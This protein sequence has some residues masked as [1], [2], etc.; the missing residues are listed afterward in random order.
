MKCPWKQSAVALLLVVSTA[1]YAD[2]PTT[3][4]GVNGAGEQIAL[5]EE[6]LPAA[7]ASNLAWTGFYVVSVGAPGE[8]PEKEFGA[9]HCG[10]R[11]ASF[12]C[13]RG[14]QS[15]LAGT[16]YGFVRDLPNCRGSL[17]IC[18]GGCGAHAPQEMIRD[19]WECPTDDGLDYYDACDPKNHANLALLASNVNLREE[20][21]LAAAVR[22]RLPKNTQVEI[23][24]RQASCLTLNH[25]RGQWIKVRVRDDESAEAGWVFDAYVEYSDLTPRP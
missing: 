12:S 24:E 8:R 2:G 14:G 9:Q 18:T 25:E 1:I 17:F 11:V 10:V 15:P 16:T 4:H 22:V 21:N 6:W 7:G 5:D 13:A 23:L 3:I 20:P 19:Y